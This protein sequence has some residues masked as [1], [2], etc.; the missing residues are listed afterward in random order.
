MLED[1]QTKKIS[2]ILQLDQ[3]KSA[4]LPELKVKSPRAP[5]AI[6]VKNRT[7]AKETKEGARGAK[8]PTSESGAGKKAN[9]KVSRASDSNDNV[10]VEKTVVMLENEVVSTP[11]VILPPAR[12]AENETCNNDRMENP[13][14]ESEY[15]IRDPPSP[16]VLTGDVSPTIHTSDN[17]LNLYEVWSIHYSFPSSFTRCIVLCFVVSMHKYFD[18]GIE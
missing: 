9:S 10:V 1:V 18:F 2:A 16:V 4:A 8:S 17:Q 15:A 5:A 13:S 7:V 3:S 12:I 14:L 6:V 11:P